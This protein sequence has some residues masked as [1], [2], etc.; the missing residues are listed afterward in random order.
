MLHQSQSRNVT[1]KMT[2]YEKFHYQIVLII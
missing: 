2:D 1:N